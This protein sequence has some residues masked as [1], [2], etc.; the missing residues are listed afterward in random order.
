MTPAVRELTILLW[1]RRHNTSLWRISSSE[2]CRTKPAVQSTVFLPIRLWERNSTLS[3]DFHQAYCPVSLTTAWS[4]H[5]SLR[6]LWQSLII[7]VPDSNH[8]YSCYKTFLCR[9]VKNCTMEFIYNGA[10]GNLALASKRNFSTVLIT[11][12]PHYTHMTFRKLLLSSTTTYVCNCLKKYPWI[13]QI[14]NMLFH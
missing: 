1:T 11:Y 4:E 14:I 5:L 9:Q 6:I 10:T 7:V 12:T 13:A 8:S 3:T 2:T